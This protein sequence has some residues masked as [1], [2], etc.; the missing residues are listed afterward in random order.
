MTA[1]IFQSLPHPLPLGAD[2][3]ESL[4]G[5]IVLSITDRLMPF[6]PLFPCVLLYVDIIRLKGI[7]V[8]SQKN[9][10]RII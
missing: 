2:H 10:R 5:P 4:P 1:R 9:Q 6:C 7:H 3:Y 8:I